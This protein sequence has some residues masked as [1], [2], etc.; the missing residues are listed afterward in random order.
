MALQRNNIIKNIRDVAMK[1]VPQGGHVWLY[2]SRARGDAREDSD[3]DLLILIDK[4]SVSSADEDRISYPFVE[5]GWQ[6]AVAISP[7]IYTYKDWQKR[8][9]SPFHR[10]VERDKIQLL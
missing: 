10:N 6:N 4:D 2:S 8:A 9:I 7:M 1:V 3:W 5:M